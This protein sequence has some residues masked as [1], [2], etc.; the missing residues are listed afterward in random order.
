MPPDVAPLDVAGV[1]DRV[2]WVV[3]VLFV[4]VVVHQRQGDVTTRFDLT[5]SRAVSRPSWEKLPGVLHYSRSPFF[6]LEL[7]SENH[8]TRVRLVNATCFTFRSRGHDEG[9][10]AR[11]GRAD[12]PREGRAGACQ[13]CEVEDRGL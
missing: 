12:G 9:R 4:R 6:V 2:V 5:R 10:A 1:S 11:T 8:V 7:D 3:A 13:L